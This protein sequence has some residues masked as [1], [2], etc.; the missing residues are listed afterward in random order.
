[1]SEMTR[2]YQQTKILIE[3]ILYRNNNAELSYILYYLC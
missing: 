3:F 1:M 2:Q